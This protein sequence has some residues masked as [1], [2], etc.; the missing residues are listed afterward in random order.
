MISYLTLST[1]YE[2]MSILN[3]IQMQLG[4]AMKRRPQL[5]HLVGA[6]PVVKPTHF[7]VSVFRFY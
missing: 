1:L 4:G 2:I 3:R 6:E 7:L 5:G